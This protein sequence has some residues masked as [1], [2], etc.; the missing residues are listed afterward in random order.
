MKFSIYSLSM[1][2]VASSAIAAPVA[3]SIES[4]AAASDQ[5]GAVTGTVND[6]LL[7]LCDSIGGTQ[8]TS[9]VCKTATGTD[10]SVGAADENGLATVVISG[11][12]LL[13]G[14]SITLPVGSAEGVLGQLSKRHSQPV[15]IA[16]IHMR[17]AC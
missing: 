16:T 1:A 4:T 11:A 5:A 14:A 8:V 12:G 7:Q 2:L 13:Q 17:C 15:S 6:L 10:V 3:Q 9:T